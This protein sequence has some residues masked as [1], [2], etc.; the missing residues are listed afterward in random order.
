MIMPLNS[1]KVGLAY[2]PTLIVSQGAKYNLQ[3]LLVRFRMNR[4]WGL[5][6]IKG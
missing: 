2:S 1:L 5:G 3:R 6:K 4:N